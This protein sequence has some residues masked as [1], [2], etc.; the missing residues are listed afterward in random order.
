MRTIRDL[1]K[2][3]LMPMKFSIDGDGS[4][5]G[6]MGAS[7]IDLGGIDASM[8]A[9]LAGDVTFDTD[10]ML[11]NNGGQAPDAGASGQ[12]GAQDPAN[13]G[14]AAAQQPA[15][16]N[17]NASDMWMWNELETR[18]KTNGTD[19]T[20][21]E[22]IKTGKKEDGTELTQ[23]DRFNMFV[24][25]LEK[26]KPQ[27]QEDSF[28]AAYKAA[29]TNQDFDMNKFLQTEQQRQAI[30]S[31]DDD[32]FLS[33]HLRSVKN[34]DGTQKH[35]ET[36]IEAYVQKLNSIEKSEKAEALRGQLRQSMEQEN[37]AKASEA[38]AQRTK[39]LEDWNNSRQTMLEATITEMASVKEIAGIPLTESDMAD[40]LP[41]FDKMT[42][43]NEKTGELYMDEYLQS[44]NSN[45]FK[46]LYLLHKADKGE[47][48]K[49]VTNVKETIKEGIF[50]KMGI[51]PNISGSNSGA[52]GSSAPTSQAY[53]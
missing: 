11:G 12:Q 49:H 3:C 25:N 30:F 42:Q 29:K 24:E 31:A 16:N 38:N 5:G 14:A 41:V 37:L 44:N 48:E 32:T 10:S 52:G 50:Q 22:V 36:D 35:A 51:K 13:G 26:N 23:Q 20:V 8:T 9:A 43:Y 6:G 7:A 15:D 40:F 2:R 18:A 46:M 4:S 45:V 27:T 47:I 19:W 53:V 39:V 28:V 34:A 17:Q 21:P 1:V 33:A